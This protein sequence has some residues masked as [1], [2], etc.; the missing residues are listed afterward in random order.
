VGA[1]VNLTKRLMFSSNIAYNS[2][3]TSGS[4]AAAYRYTIWNASMAYRFLPGNN[5]ELKVSGLDLLNQNKGV[6]SYGSNLAYTHGTVNILRQ[7]F[8]VTIA[9]YPRKFGKKMGG[10]HN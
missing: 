8:M 1:G 6:V 4:G 10:G 9:Y 5:L 7:Y 2:F 3:I